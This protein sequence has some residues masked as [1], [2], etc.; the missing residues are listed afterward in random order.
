MAWL[1]QEDDWL[2][3]FDNADD[4]LTLRTYLPPHRTGGK[5]L[6]TSRAKSFVAVGIKEPFLVE[7]L[8]S[9]AAVK[10]LIER[11]GNS[12]AQAAAVL[13]LELGYLP[14]AL[15]QAAA[16]IETVGGGFA[17]Y[18]T[19]YQRQGVALFT[20]SKPST[21]YPK[22]VATTWTLSFDAVRLVSLASAELLISVAFVAPDAVPIEIFTL[23]GAEF[24]SK[25]SFLLRILD[26]L[27]HRTFAGE[28]LSKALVTSSED[29]LSFWE[30]LEPLER[31][32]LVHRLPNN[33]FKLHRLTQ[34]VIKD[35]LDEEGRRAWTERIVRALNAAYPQAEFENWNL[36]ERLQPSARLAYDLAR[37][38][39]IKSTEAGR[40]F[41]QAGSFSSARG[42]HGSAQIFLEFS[43]EIWNRLL[44]SAHPDTLTAKNNLAV[45]L[46]ASGDLVVAKKLFTHIL[47]VQ[48]DVLGNEHP[49]TLQSRN[50]LAVTLRALGDLLGA[51]KLHEQSLEIQERLLGREH[52]ETTLS[53]WN[54]LLTVHEF[55]DPEAASQLISKLDWL[56]QRDEDSIQS[57]TQRKIRQLLLDS[58]NSS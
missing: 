27:F 45:S 24:G 38:Y 37:K 30:L 13:A 42:D 10:F 19:R 36:C 58:L 34:E 20:K 15:E 23:G 57:V 46:Q 22:T 41:N 3:V 4:P 5:I 55:N 18:L 28:D 32:S 7:T 29:S 52:P 21:G 39:K 53:T 14:L 12:D 40:L 25:R 9:E 50:N 6:L 33:T 26:R 44:G 11:T 54:L 31:Y 16:Y 56:I 47:E 35:T 49:I 51:K 48:R 8:E 17:E 2:L 1:S 43:V